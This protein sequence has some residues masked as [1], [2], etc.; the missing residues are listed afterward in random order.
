M[1]RQGQA[2][3]RD[4]LRKEV[5]G[6]RGDGASNVVDAVIRSLRRKLGSRASTIETVS[7]VGYRFCP[8][9]TLATLLFVVIVGSTERAVALGDARWRALLDRFYDTVRTRAAEFSGR[10][11]HTAGDGVLASFEAPAAALRTACA[12]RDAVAALGIATRAGVHTGESEI[13]G[14][15]V[16]GISVHVAARIAAEGRA[17]EVLASSTVRDLVAGSGVRLADYGLHRLKDVP[18]P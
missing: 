5:W 14:D 15:D 17:G 7:G 2:V 12:I 18:E 13:I 1:R 9:R 10:V 11:V 8:E 3:S 16:A 6:H 4:V